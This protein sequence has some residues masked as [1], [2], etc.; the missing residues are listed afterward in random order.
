VNRQVLEDPLR[1][2]EASGSGTAEEDA[3]WVPLVRAG[4]KRVDGV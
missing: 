4:V 1:A 2:E 3:E